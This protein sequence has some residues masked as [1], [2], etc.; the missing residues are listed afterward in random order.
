[1]SVGARPSAFA[2]TRFGFPKGVTR[3]TLATIGTN[4]IA[5]EAVPARFRSPPAN[6]SGAVRYPVVDW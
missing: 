1:L 3:Q 2:T 6:C 5:D 4:A